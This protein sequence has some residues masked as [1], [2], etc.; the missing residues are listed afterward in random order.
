[1]ALFF[2]TA[3]DIDPEAQSLNKTHS[4]HLLFSPAFA[5][6]HL[7]PQAEFAMASNSALSVSQLVGPV[8]LAVELQAM[9]SGII[10]AMTWRYFSYFGNSDRRFYR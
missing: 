3:P 10:C 7:C 5:P 4:H 6:N 1:L 8:L 9:L 2:P